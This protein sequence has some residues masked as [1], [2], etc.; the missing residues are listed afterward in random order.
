MRFNCDYI[1]DRL[2]ERRKKKYK[3]NKWFAWYP[4]KVANNDCRFLEYVNCRA[5]SGRHVPFTSRYEYEAVDTPTKINQEV[6]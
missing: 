6:L 3:W 4:V 1:I 5:Y 2:E